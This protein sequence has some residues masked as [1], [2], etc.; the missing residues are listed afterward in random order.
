MII[1]SKIEGIVPSLCWR[2]IA[3]YLYA[4]IVFVP[5][6][7]F[8]LF[9][10]HESTVVIIFICFCFGQFFDGVLI[11]VDLVNPWENNQILCCTWFEIN[12]GIVVA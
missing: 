4:I 6:I 3:C 5:T 10:N 8:K 12:T 11:D 7:G 1:S 2:D 9:P